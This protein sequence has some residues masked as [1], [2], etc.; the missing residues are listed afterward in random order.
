MLRILHKVY[1]IAYYIKNEI[2]VNEKLVGLF[3]FFLFF[4][5]RL[6]L[7]RILFLHNLYD[8]HVNW[9]ESLFS[10]TNILNMKVNGLFQF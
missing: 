5:F 2:K 4:F 1:I 7:I 6:D 8:Q 9:V 3:S 10:K